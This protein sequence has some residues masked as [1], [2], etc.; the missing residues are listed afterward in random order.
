VA[1]RK[2]HHDAEDDALDDPGEDVVDPQE[3]E[4]DAVVEGA[5]LD[6]E[7]AVAAIRSAEERERVGEDRGQEEGDDDRDEAW[8]DQEGDGVDGEDA[9]RIDLL[10][11]DHGSELGRVV[12]AD[13]AV[14]HE[15]GEQGG[16]FAQDAE[17][18]GPS[19]QAVCAET[20]HERRGLDHDEGAGEKGRDNDDGRGFDAHFVEVAH[21]LFAIDAQCH[22]APEDARAEDEHAA[23]GSGDFEKA[24]ADFFED[25]DVGWRRP[26]R[27]Q[28]ALGTNTIWRLIRDSHEVC[29]GTAHRRGAMLA[30]EMRP[31]VCRANSGRIDA[32]RLVWIGAVRY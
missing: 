31:V 17:A 9:E 30:Y 18:R 19:K 4:R 6:A 24:A 10:G 23:D 3:A 25:A 5:R 21:Q 28:F 27:R 11:D 1:A 29:R 12:G 15:R 16:D 32:L 26:N 7:E 20:N 2:T 22:D 14:D 8:C 13:A